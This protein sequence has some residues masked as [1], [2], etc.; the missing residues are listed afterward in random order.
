MPTTTLNV[1]NNGSYQV[2][3]SAVLGDTR[4]GTIEYS[5]NNSTWT[6]LGSPMNTNAGTFRSYVFVWQGTLTGMTSAQETVYWR[7]N[8]NNVGSIFA[9][10]YQALYIDIDNTT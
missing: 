4:N 8:W 6:S 1:R 5:Y 7:V 2:I 9:N 10:T 3:Y